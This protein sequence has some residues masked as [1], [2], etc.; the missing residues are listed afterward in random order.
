MVDKYSERR[1]V[2][3]NITTACSLWQIRSIFLKIASID[4]I[5][6]VQFATL[7]EGKYMLNLKRYWKKLKQ[8][9]SL[10]LFKIKLNVLANF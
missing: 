5:L 1:R 6:I 8:K 2:E 4:C 10:D 3:E 9:F 7:F